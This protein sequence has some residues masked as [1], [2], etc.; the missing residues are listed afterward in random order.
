[1]EPEEVLLRQ[2]VLVVRDAACEQDYEPVWPL[3]SQVAQDGPAALRLGTALL[4]SGDPAERAV[5]C[6]LLG[7][8]SDLHEAQREAAASALLAAGATERDGDVQWSIARALGATADPRAV[9]LLVRLTG[10][11]DPDVRFQVALSLPSVWSGDP[12]GAEV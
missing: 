8:T 2:A 10:H 3:L 4:Q 5:G 12:A 6:D 1:M 9:P 11:A 7:V